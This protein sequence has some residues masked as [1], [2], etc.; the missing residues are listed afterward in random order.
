MIAPKNY[1]FNI[2]FEFKKY[3]AINPY[4]LSCARLLYGVVLLE[5]ARFTAM[6]ISVLLTVSVPGLWLLSI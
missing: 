2:L 6:Q 3:F 5:L 4:R 1:D